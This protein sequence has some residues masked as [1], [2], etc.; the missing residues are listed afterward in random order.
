MKKQCGILKNE[1]ESGQDNN[2]KLIKTS[3]T[4]EAFRL[5]ESELAQVSGGKPHTLKDKK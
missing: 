2:K 5:N 4:E 3:S 1:R